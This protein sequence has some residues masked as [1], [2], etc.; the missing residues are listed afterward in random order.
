MASPLVV[1][2]FPAS[3]VRLHKRLDGAL[4]QGCL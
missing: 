1:P 3:S 2:E 4:C